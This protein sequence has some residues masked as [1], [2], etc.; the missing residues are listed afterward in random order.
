MLESEQTRRIN[1]YPG[2]MV[3]YGT[4]YELSALSR[5]LDALESAQP[6]A[7]QPPP[8]GGDDLVRRADVLDACR[9]WEDSVR[10]TPFAG[11]LA[12]F[13]QL[14][15]PVPAQPSDAAAMKRAIEQAVDRVHNPRDNDDR[16]RAI[17]DCAYAI[18]A[19][20]IPVPPARTFAD[21]VEAAAKWCEKYARDITITYDE[22]SGLFAVNVNVATDLAAAIRKLKETT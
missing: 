11:T 10:T 8:P 3:P 7:E 2:S 4:N 13:I 19:T 17:C 9:R 14:V 20:P 5:R 22:P 1:S 6:K 21:G 15:P 18:S 16:T 12:H